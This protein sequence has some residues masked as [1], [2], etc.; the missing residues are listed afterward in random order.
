MLIITTEATVSKKEIYISMHF[1]VFRQD[2]FNIDFLKAIVS[3]FYPMD[4][5]ITA[6]VNPFT[7][8]SLFKFKDRLH[9]DMNSGVVY[10]FVP[11]VLWE[12][13]PI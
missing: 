5:L 9:I 6:P 11:N 4:S 3:K 8:G 1:L 2:R 13:S 10:L 7:I 12:L